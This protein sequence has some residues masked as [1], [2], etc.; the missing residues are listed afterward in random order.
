MKDQKL[1]E[2]IADAEGLDEFQ[3][4]SSIAL[5]TAEDVTPSVMEPLPRDRVEK[6]YTRRSRLNRE[7]NSPIKGFEYLLDMLSTTTADKISIHALFKSGK[8]YFVF[9]DPELNELLGIL[10]PLRAEKKIW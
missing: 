6:I 5:A 4:L 8:K 3:W 10:G 7:R 2:L 1:R 9:T